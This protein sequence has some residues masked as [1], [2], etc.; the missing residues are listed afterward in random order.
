MDEAMSLCSDR[1]RAYFLPHVAPWKW[2]HFHFWAWFVS[3]RLG[4]LCLYLRGTRGWR[5]HFLF[6]SDQSDM[7]VVA[8]DLLLRH[9]VAHRF[10]VLR[11][12]GRSAFVDRENDLKMMCLC[13]LT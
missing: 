12:G 13:P 11:L 2:L 10:P 1:W 9:H 3:L 8:F 6:L 7:E 5:H 4:T